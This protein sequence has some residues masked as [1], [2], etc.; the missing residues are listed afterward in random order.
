MTNTDIALLVIELQFGNKEALGKLYQHFHV[1]MR[2]YAVLRVKDSMIADDLVQNVWA[3]VAKRVTKLNDV[4]LFKSWLYRALRWEIVDWYRAS[5][6]EVPL[7]SDMPEKAIEVVFS[8]PLS[9]LKH[10]L[11][12]PTNERDVAELFYLND[13][14]IQEISLVTNV[15]LGTVKSRLHR[16]RSLLKQRISK[17]EYGYEE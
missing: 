11:T 14:N 2:K 10:L 3:K 13:L 16:A 7:H 1:A 4:S 12:L 15:P 5:S 17:T 8:E 9:P 6:K